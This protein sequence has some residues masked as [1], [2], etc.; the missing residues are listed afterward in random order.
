VAF[1]LEGR[2]E[3]DETAL[4]MLDSKLGSFRKRL[5]GDI[6][7]EPFGPHWTHMY[8]HWRG[9]SREPDLAGEAAE[10]L[11]EFIRLIEPFRRR[12]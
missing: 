2:P 7:L 11:A 10:R 3:D 12:A 1:H 9:A 4:R 8:E 6:R 5:G